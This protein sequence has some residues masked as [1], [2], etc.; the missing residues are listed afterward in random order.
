MF[1]KRDIAS[2]QAALSAVPTSMPS[3]LPTTNL[4]ID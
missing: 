2:S 3:G 1:P 4:P